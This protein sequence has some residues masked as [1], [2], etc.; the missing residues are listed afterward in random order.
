MAIKNQLKVELWKENIGTTVE[1]NEIKEE[2]SDSKENVSKEKK[3]IK[4]KIKKK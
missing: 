4:F 3:P 1:K 2:K